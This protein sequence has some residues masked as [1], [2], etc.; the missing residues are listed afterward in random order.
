M[1]V[2]AYLK[3]HGMWLSHAPI[4]P[5]ELRGKPSVHGHCHYANIQLDGKDDPRYLAR[6]LATLDEVR[7]YFKTGELIP[8]GHI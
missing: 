1:K 3:E 8:I 4:H 6:P 5:D 2:V 7:N